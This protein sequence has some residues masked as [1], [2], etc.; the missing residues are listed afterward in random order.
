MFVPLW[1]LPQVLLFPRRSNSNL[2]FRHGPSVFKDKLICK[3]SKQGGLGNIFGY[4]PWFFYFQEKRIS[5]NNLYIRHSHF[6]FQNLYFYMH[7]LYLYFRHGSFQ[8]S[9]FIFQHAYFYPQNINELTWIIQIRFYYVY[10]HQPCTIT[11]ISRN[12]CI[13][14]EINISQTIQKGIE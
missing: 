3:C 13:F 10:A 7:T 2:Y 9:E 6:S 4:F 8:F 11:I 5:D 12:V 1:I 14:E